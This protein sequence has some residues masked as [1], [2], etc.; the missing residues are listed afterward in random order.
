MLPTNDNKAYA[1][2]GRQCVGD[3]YMIILILAEVRS[4]T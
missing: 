1:N 3:Y 4:A 2:A